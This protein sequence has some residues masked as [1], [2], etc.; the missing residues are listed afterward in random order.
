MSTLYCLR[1]VIFMK[2]NNVLKYFMLFIFSFIISFFFVYVLMPTFCDEIW[3][4][5][6]SY[7][8]SK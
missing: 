7:N 1:R 3:T 8:I 5:G 2:R 6:F 4:Y